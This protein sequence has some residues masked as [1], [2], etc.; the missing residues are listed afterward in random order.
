MLPL[1][2]DA[3]RTRNLA[4]I[5]GSKLIVT[6]KKRNCKTLEQLNFFYSKVY[7]ARYQFHEDRKS[8][9]SALITLF[10]QENNTINSRYSNNS[11]ETI[12][13]KNTYQLFL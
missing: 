8:S 2:D 6:V 11:D 5:R 10:K 7:L 1:L 3:K 12:K 4:L 9:N 13:L